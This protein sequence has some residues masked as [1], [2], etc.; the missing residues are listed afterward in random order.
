LIQASKAVDFLAQNSLQAEL[1][2]KHFG[3]ASRVT[4]VGM[5]A[6]TT[7]TVKVFN[8]SRQSNTVSYDFVFHATS[9]IAKG[10]LYFV[11]LAHQLPDRSF[12]IPDDK[13]RI[14]RILNIEIPDNIT[15]RSI[16]WEEGLEDLVVSARVVVNPSMWSAPI[17]GALIKSA[18]RNRNVATV[19]S[20][21]GFESEIDSI[22]N[23]L[24]LDPDPISGAQQL[25]AFLTSF[26]NS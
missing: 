10:L 2:R 23:H 13:D 1:I 11:Q 25:E 7:N 9:L 12:F 21:Y 3:I 8:F 15:C 26:N 22:V 4:V 19:V 18:S 5:D 17:E 24:R 20:R 16:T 6:E 14:S